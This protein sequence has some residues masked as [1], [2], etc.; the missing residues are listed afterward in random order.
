MV[1]PARLDLGD[2]VLVSV[3]RRDIAAALD[4][5][6]ARLVHQLIYP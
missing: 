5:P 3:G 6:P 4:W 1:P 2:E